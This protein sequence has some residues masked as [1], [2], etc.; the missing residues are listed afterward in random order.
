[1]LKNCKEVKL[2]KKLSNSGDHMPYK[3]LITTS[4]VGSRLGSLTDYTNK[5]LVSIG[6]KNS[7]AYIIE[8][9]PPNIIF[10]ITLGHF[11]EH[12]REFLQIS[13][14][15]RFFEFVEVDNFNGPGSSLAFSMLAAKSYLQQPFIFHASDTIIYSEEIPP[16][17]NNW[18]FGFKSLDADNYA[19]FD[20]E[21]HKVLGIH[22]KGMTEF[23]F[24]H[25][26]L[27]GIFNFSDF[28]SNLE[29]I[30]KDNLLSNPTDVNVIRSLIKS[31]IEFNSIETKNWLDIGNS[32]SLMKAK[33]KF[34]NS[35][36]TLP[37]VDESIIFIGNS[38]VK[39]FADPKINKNR[40]SRAKFLNGLVPNLE[41]SNNYFL[42][43]KYIEG[44]VLSKV[45]NAHLI[46]KLLDWAQKKL[47]KPK[48]NFNFLEFRNKCDNFYFEKTL[49]RINLFISSRGI[50]DRTSIINGY[51]IPPAFELLNESRDH[52]LQNIIETGY[53]GDFILDNIIL[54]NNDFKL[55]DW[56]QDFGGDLEFGDKYYDLA[57]LNH[58]LVINHAIVNSKLFEIS[59]SKSEVSCTILRKD[60]H[61][62]MQ[63][64]LGKFVF[65]QNLSK[66]KVDILTSVIWLNMSPLHHHPFDL[67]LYN[68]GK[69]NLWK[70]LNSE[71]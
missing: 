57:K 47:W 11:G 32:S 16:P 61:V 53:H 60:I 52:L 12:V 64:L 55:I 51:E 37:K 45:S 65:E 70:A 28:W 44:D 71:E 62:E 43:Y 4:G 36:I 18:I 19:T 66:Q 30:L 1:M 10:V 50:S 8:S 26:G 59:I 29:E 63:K 54:E 14:P 20:I 25:I 21:E 3:V 17:T 48:E 6:R 22:E 35:F 27:I 13:Y 24:I 9:Y 46:S 23:D 68:Y 42:K 56:R 40:V 41:D 39:F 5:C 34:G 58:S 69:L 38:V 49:S 33:E 67:F 31:G 7:L 15:D 2:G